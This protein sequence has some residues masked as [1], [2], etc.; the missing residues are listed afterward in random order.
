MYLY[1]NKY[2]YTC[3]YIYTVL[4]P[5]K[6]G[7]RIYIHRYILHIYIYMYAYIYVHL[8]LHIHR[9]DEDAG[10]SMATSQVVNISIHKY[11]L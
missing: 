10:D 11:I 5:A 4:A 2:I 1:I 8:H 6:V 9:I 7:R 3:T